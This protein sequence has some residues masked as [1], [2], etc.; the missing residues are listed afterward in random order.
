[1][2]WMDHE[3]SESH[4]FIQIQHKHWKL[5]Y[6][7]TIGFIGFIGWTGWILKRYLTLIKPRLDT[8]MY[9]SSVVGIGI[10]F[11]SLTHSHIEPSNKV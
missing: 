3:S 4:Q 1:V 9:Y 2:D 7:S 5:S 6:Y 8:S 10:E 11:Q